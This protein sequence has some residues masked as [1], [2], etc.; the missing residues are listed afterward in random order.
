MGDRVIFASSGKPCL[1]AL[2]RTRY[3]RADKRMNRKELTRLFL[4][5]KRDAV[6]KL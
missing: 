1:S 4:L 2:Y 5:L 3:K 6:S